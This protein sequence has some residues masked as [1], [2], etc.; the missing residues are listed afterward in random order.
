MHPDAIFRLWQV[1]VLTAI[2]GLSLYN[3]G[4]LTKLAP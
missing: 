4:I 1:V 2:L 3:A